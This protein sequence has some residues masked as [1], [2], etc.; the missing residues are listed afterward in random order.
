MAL[1]LFW[2]NRGGAE[3]VPGEWESQGSAAF[4][5]GSNWVDA[6]ANDHETAAIRS[7]GTL[8][9]SEQPRRTAEEEVLQ[10]AEPAA[11]L[12]QFAQETNWLRVV[13]RGGMA[14]LLLKRDG[15]LWAWGTNVYETKHEYPSLRRF[16]PRLLGRDS[17]WAR[18]IGSRWW[19]GAFLWKTDGSGWILHYPRTDLGT[20]LI[21]KELAP[22]IFAWHLPGLDNARW[23]SLVN[24]DYHSFAGV[25]DDGTLWY[26]AG[27]P[28]HWP[29][30]WSPK[31]APANGWIPVQIGKA[32]DWAEL[33]NTT[34]IVGRKMDGSLWLWEAKNWWE[35]F[36]VLGQPPV[37]L[38]INRDW[39]AL[40][41]VDGEI[42]SVAADGILWDWPDSRT[43]VDLFYG[44]RLAASR[45][46]TRIENILGAH[47]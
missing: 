22:G 10:N 4:V 40:G 45:K 30:P 7:D 12:I 38:G 6:A 28:E 16:A 19:I 20:N 41:A 37:R 21:E 36:K 47:E 26:F 44:L 39:I 29:Q 18:M 9:V 33:A 24:L 43:P 8:W 23:R 34:R 5:P 17:D 3:R 46:P 42:T 15:T 1:G 35:A 31:A 14:M 32:S 13:C 2:Q 27:Y 25:R 11:G